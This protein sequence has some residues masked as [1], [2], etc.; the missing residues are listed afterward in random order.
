MHVLVS[1]IQY[2]LRDWRI[3]RGR[4]D[5]GPE[6]R[7]RV[8]LT[9]GSVGG[10]LASLGVFIG[11]SVM[12]VMLTSLVDVYFVA[13]IGALELA[14]ISFTVPVV[15]TVSA[16]TVGLGN[17]VVAVVA[18]AAGSGDHDSIRWLATDSMLLGLIIVVLLSVAGYATIEPL[19]TLLG[20]DEKVIPLIRQ[21]MHIWY[22]GAGFQ[23][24]P[25]LG[26]NIIRALGNTRIPSAITLVMCVANIALDPIL[27]LG[28]GPVPAM[29]LEGAA[30]AYILSRLISFVGVLVVLH[31]RFHVLAAVS[32]DMVRLRE[33]WGRLLHIGLPSTATQMVLPLSMAILTKVVA[34]SG[35]MAV[36]AYGVATRIEFLT[37]IYLWAIAGALAAFVGQ[38][39]G[40]GRMDRVQAAVRA[41]IKSCIV[42]GI[43]MVAIALIAGRQIIAQFTDNPEIQTLAVFYLRVAS[44][45]FPVGGLVLVAA[46][47]MNALARPI[48]AAFVSLLRTCLVTVPCA[49]IG[50]WLGQI[51]GA[52]IGIAVGNTLSGAIAWITV[53][54]ILE[55]ESHR[56]TKRPESD[57]PKVIQPEAPGGDVLTS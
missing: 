9:E 32:F 1:R 23:I 53:L 26:Q 5:A 18:R 39:A 49:L 4:A 25:S 57:V 6:R 38:N 54:R 29:G 14:A 40:A 20:A 24:I 44:A 41:S 51:H 37:A 10:H 19:F 13:K 8:D 31:Y 55:T 52:F 30:I 15:V 7:G 42:T 28:W 2:F 16:L 50:Q 12:A 27:I 21:Y 33:S 11:L 45:A 34:L 3:F 47:T 36:A 17:G 48:P 46:Q 43:F 22:L 56:Q 35:T